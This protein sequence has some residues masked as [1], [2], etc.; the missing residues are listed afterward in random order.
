MFGRALLAM[1]IAGT[2]SVAPGVGAAV[3]VTPGN[4]WTVTIDAV[5]PV[6]I[7]P[8]TFTLSGTITQDAAV[9]TPVVFECAGVCFGSATTTDPLGRATVTA[10]GVW[11]SELLRTIPAAD[12]VKVRAG[13]LSGQA[14]VWFDTWSPWITMRF[15]TD[16]NIRMRIDGP[17][18]VASSGDLV[19]VGATAALADGTVL[20]VQQ[21]MPD[22]SW[23]GLSSD[24]GLPAVVKVSGNKFASLIGYEY[25]F[26][27]PPWTLRLSWFYGAVPPTSDSITITSDGPRKPPCTVTS[28][29]GAD[30]VV[31]PCAG[32]GTTGTGGT[33]TGPGGTST[34]QVAIPVKVKRSAVTGYLAKKQV[35]K[36]KLQRMTASGG[37][38]T[39]KTKK[40]STKTGKVKFTALK[41]HTQY[42]LYAPRKNTLTVAYSRMFSR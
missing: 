3:A 22:G 6:I 32:S 34:D 38:K 35:R 1:V 14:P 36:V 8:G 18:S 7:N 11:T 27:P 17:T 25:P 28:P 24:W 19:L 30:T 31:D 9:G 41:K 15:S 29:A 26:G 5:P 42:R 39:V 33:T 12:E 2:L 40:T 10:P 4:Q 21:R 20:A 13:V 37:W 23:R 16:P